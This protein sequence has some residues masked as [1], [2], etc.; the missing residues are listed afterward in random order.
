MNKE[1]YKRINNLDI[2]LCKT[3]HNYI[4][5]HEWAKD[6]SHRWGIAVFEF[7][8]KDDYW[9]FKTYG[10]FN[11]KS[12]DWYDFGCLINLGYAWIDKNCFDKVSDGN[13]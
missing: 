6:N 5:I 7:N 9:F 4:M 13:E 2:E 3:N 12:V 10:N 1:Y 11:N 8:D